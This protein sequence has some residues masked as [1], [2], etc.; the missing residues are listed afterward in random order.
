MS[1]RKLGPVDGAARAARAVA[2]CA[3][4]LV[5]AGCAGAVPPSQGGQATVMLRG[6]ELGRFLVDEQGHSLYLFARDEEKESYCSGACASIWPPYETSGEVSAG[7]GVS[8]SMLTTFERE[9]GDLQVA[10]AGHPLYY[11][12]GDGSDPGSTDG[13]GLA[14]FGAEWYL[15][16][17]D[18]KPVESEEEGEGES[19]EESRR[20]AAVAEEQLVAGAEV[21]MPGAREAAR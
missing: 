8:P 11:Y 7:A 10:Y 4:G 3:A 17:A 6:S 20:G 21:S 13:E 9:D 14:Q 12:A 2:A 16:G 1:G 5:L 19:G 15:V 18:G